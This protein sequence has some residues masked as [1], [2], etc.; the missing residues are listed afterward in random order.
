[1]N[2]QSIQE[3]NSKS[4][5]AVI[6][7][8]NE[9]LKAH[10]GDRFEIVSSAKTY[11]KDSANLRIQ[12][13]LPGGNSEGASDAAGNTHYVTDEKTFDVLSSFHGISQG[14]LGAVFQSRGK[15]FKL[16][17]ILPTRNPNAKR[18]FMIK[19]VNTGKVYRT[20]AFSLRG[21]LSK[22]QI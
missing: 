6:N 9:V 21:F 11:Q 18:I 20:D 5:T 16:I 7:E 15:T 22:A 10:F 17:G 2:V 8:A 1:M 14:K 13:K 19:E 12:I 4:A 3:F